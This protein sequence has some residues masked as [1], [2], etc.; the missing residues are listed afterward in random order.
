[1]LAREQC[2]GSTIQNPLYA[3]GRAKE[4]VYLAGIVGVPW[5][6]IAARNAVDGT[7]LPSDVLRFKTAAELRPDGWDR[8][9]GG[10]EASPPEAPTDILMQEST[11]PRAGV[12]LGGPNGREYATDAA[13]AGTP[14]DLEYA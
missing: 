13:T 6:D 11:L 3:G 2:P 7:P 12:V 1:M 4:S 14:E 5:Q 8:I 9:L 10:P